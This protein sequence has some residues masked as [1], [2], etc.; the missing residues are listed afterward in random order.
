MT[1][2]AVMA[3]MT[4]RAEMVARAAGQAQIVM[5]EA[6]REEEQREDSSHPHCPLEVPT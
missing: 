6:C 2:T 1:V 4:A 5:S 3:V